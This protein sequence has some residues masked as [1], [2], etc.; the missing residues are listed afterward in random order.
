MLTELLDPIIKTTGFKVRVFCNKKPINLN[1]AY[2][3][4]VWDK[5]KPEV[6]ELTAKTMG[7]F[8]L[9]LIPN[10]DFLIDY[11]ITNADIRLTSLLNTHTNIYN[12]S[13]GKTKVFSSKYDF[14]ALPERG[15]INI[16]QKDQTALFL[17]GGRDS[18]LTYGLMKEAGH[19]VTKI[20]IQ[21]SAAWWFGPC[22]VYR[23][24]GGE[25]IREDTS[26]LYPVLKKLGNNIR[27]EMNALLLW[28]ALSIPYI[29]KD[30]CNYLLYGNEA[31]TSTKFRY[32]KKTHYDYSWNQCEEATN[33]VDQYFA[34]LFKRDKSRLPGVR[35]GSILRPFNTI[36]IQRI[37]CEHYPD[38][39]KHQMSCNSAQP[40]YSTKPV[41]F[42]NCSSC[43]KCHRTFL[44]LD[45]LG[46]DVSVVNLDRKKVLENPY[47]LLQLMRSEGLCP[48]TPEELFYVL[49]LKNSY[50][51]DICVPRIDDT[52]KGDYD[53]FNH[54]KANMDFLPKDLFKKLYS[55]A[56]QYTSLKDLPFM[57]SYLDIN[58]EKLKKRKD[59]PVYNFKKEKVR[60]L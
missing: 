51:P 5:T 49:S 33:I 25:K 31:V 21:P 10:S 60:R 57:D 39:Y 52:G 40:D 48:T 15:L 32:R 41:T 43:E 45:A 28:S 55:I 18:L 42:K 38:L 27:L 58:Y 19:E 20:F 14:E 22:S 13:L 24:I 29:V 11:P 8:Y 30:N 56:F 2:Y 36:T 12:A 53:A 9:S 4:D 16:E 17:S 46:K 37:L 1:V 50:F 59:L 34:T 44:I 23:E 7:L 47:S 6:K 35:V 3:G 54:W 26:R